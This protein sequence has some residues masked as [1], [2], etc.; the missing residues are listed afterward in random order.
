MTLP[1]RRPD[2]ALVRDFAVAMKE[3]R[4]RHGW[5]QEDLRGEIE[6]LPQSIRFGY[7]PSIEEIAAVEDAEV[8]RLPAWVRLARMASEQARLSEAQR[9]A[10]LNER[11]WYRP[12]Y[13]GGDPGDMACPWVTRDE[14]YLLEH[15]SWIPSEERDLVFRLARALRRRDG[16]LFMRV[17]EQIGELIGED[18]DGDALPPRADPGRGPRGVSGDDTDDDDE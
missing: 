14:F 5:T 4:A 13:V 18:E 12:G 17:L 11:Q 3:E 1:R 15:L 10:W 8:K 7:I 2:S 9:G 6:Q 16:A